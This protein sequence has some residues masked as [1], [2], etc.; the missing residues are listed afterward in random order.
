MMDRATRIILGLYVGGIGFFSFLLLFIVVNP[1]FGIG[2]LVS[3]AILGLSMESITRDKWNNGICKKYDEPWEFT[4][5]AML[6]D[7]DMCYS[8]KCRDKE[9]T[10]NSSLVGSLRETYKGKKPIK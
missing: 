3:M 7:G 9:V 2:L 6:S 5:S 10:L 8:F 1:W 4:D